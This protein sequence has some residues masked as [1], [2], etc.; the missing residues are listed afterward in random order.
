M[1]TRAEHVVHVRCY[2]VTPRLAAHRMRLQ[3]Q[4]AAPPPRSIIDCVFFFCAAAIIVPPPNLRR[5][6]PRRPMNG[7]LTGHRTHH[8]KRPLETSCGRISRTWAHLWDN[9]VN[10]Q[11]PDYA[12]A[13]TS[14]HPP[15]SAYQYK[16]VRTKFK[17]DF[18]HIRRDSA[19]C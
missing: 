9:R 10:R 12:T 16:L 7:R 3:K 14:S 6:P 15:F 11:A 2:L 5:L 18:L 13:E 8:K 17:T 1:F 19:I 4:L